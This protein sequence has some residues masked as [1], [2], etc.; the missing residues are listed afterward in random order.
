MAFKASP[1]VSD[2][3]LCALEDTDG[4]APAGVGVDVSEAGKIGSK[5]VDEGRGGTV[6]FFDEVQ[7]RPIVFFVE[8]LAG[9]AE[10]V[11]SFLE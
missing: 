6:C 8:D 1:Q 4:L 3:D 10:T 2:E 5:E 11:E 9:F 7:D